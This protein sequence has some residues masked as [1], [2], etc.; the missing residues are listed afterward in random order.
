MNF[1]VVVPT[2][3]PRTYSQC[4]GYRCRNLLE[5]TK[6]LELSSSSYRVRNRAA[7][8]AGAE[9]NFTVGSHQHGLHGIARAR[10]L[11]RINAKH[12]C[13]VLMEATHPCTTYTA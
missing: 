9:G 5:K 7:P 10:V 4:R 1:V 3:L 12:E 6:L 8:K 2:D 11:Q 13:S